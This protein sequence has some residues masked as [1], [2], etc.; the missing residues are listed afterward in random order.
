MLSYSGLKKIAAASYVAT[1]LN[2]SFIFLL[3]HCFYCFHFQCYYWLHYFLYLH[4]SGFGVSVGSGFSVGFGVAVGVADGV[5]FGVAVGV[6]DGVGVTDGVGVADG[7][8]V[9]VGDVS[10]SIVTLAT[11]DFTPDE[12]SSVTVFT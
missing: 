9:G 6:A 3:S 5:G 8:G 7:V 4:S 11:L 12:S 10:P 2:L 1:A